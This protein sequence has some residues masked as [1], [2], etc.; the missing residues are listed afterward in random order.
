MAVDCCHP[1]DPQFYSRTLEA[2]ANTSWSPVSP[3]LSSD[4]SYEDNCSSP[5]LPGEDQPDTEQPSCSSSVL[6][7]PSP[8]GEASADA[9]TPNAT[10]PLEPQAAAQIAPEDVEDEPL[11]SSSEER[12]VMYPVRQVPLQ[13]HMSP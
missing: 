10:G 7:S 4:G 1:L 6:E 5:V 3:S 2:V 13:P 9:V 11:L 8:H 12:F